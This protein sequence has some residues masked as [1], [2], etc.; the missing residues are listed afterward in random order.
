MFLSPNDLGRIG[1]G[2]LCTDDYDQ[3]PEYGGDLRKTH[4][5]H[6]CVN[7]PPGVMKEL[8]GMVEV[9]NACYRYLIYIF[10]KD[11]E[12][13]PRPFYTRFWFLIVIA[14]TKVRCPI[15]PKSSG[16]KRKHT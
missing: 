12:L 2:C 1:H 5:S 10:K 3:K 7:T 4:G 6:G 16:E 8:S 9:G 14:S 15:R 13:F 11:G